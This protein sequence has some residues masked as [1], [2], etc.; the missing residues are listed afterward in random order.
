MKAIPIGQMCLMSNC[1]NDATIDFNDQYY[2]NSCYNKTIERKEVIAL[3]TERRVY[4]LPISAPSTLSHELQS[5]LV[6][7]LSKGMIIESDSFDFEIIEVE[8]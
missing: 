4:N 3:W 8:K 6:D 7:N 5:W 2:C 1:T